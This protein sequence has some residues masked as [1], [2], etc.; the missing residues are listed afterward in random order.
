MQ[1]CTCVTSPSPRWR[2]CGGGADPLQHIG[3]G[4]RLERAHDIAMTKQRPAERLAVCDRA[5]MAQLI[6]PDDRIF[7]SGQWVPVKSCSHGIV[8]DAGQRFTTSF[9]NLPTKSAAG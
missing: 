5:S 2:T 1:R 4:R 7:T 9:T 3:V 6:G 8:F